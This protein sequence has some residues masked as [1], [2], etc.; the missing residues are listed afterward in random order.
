MQL[1]FLDF[2]A[3]VNLFTIKPTEMTRILKKQCTFGDGYADCNA[4]LPNSYRTKQHKI[5]IIYVVA[6]FRFG[7]LE[8]HMNNK[9]LAASKERL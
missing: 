9:S 4:K 1:H 3:S 8:L 2:E 6:G 7:M 5:P